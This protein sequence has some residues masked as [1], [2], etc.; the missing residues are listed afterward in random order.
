MMRQAFLAL[1]YALLL[2]SC[3]SPA[4][5]TPPNMAFMEIPK[6]GGN[7]ATSTPQAAPTA[8]LPT[9]ETLRVAIW[10]PPYLAETLSGTF[11]EP[12]KGMFV[13]E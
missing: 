4:T 11:L 8:S 7:Q 5:A 6:P 3:A 1:L 2:T 9:A 10:M 12:L 13:T